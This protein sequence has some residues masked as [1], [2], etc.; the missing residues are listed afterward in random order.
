[1]VDNLLENITILYSCQQLHEL[2]LHLH[3]KL[4]FL[5]SLFFLYCRKTTIEATQSSCHF[6]PIT[7]ILKEEMSDKHVL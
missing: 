5:Y 4:M 3:L 6:P 2:N 7:Y 1:M